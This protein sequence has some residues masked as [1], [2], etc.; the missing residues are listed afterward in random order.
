VIAAK[1]QLG[2]KVVPGATSARKM[3]EIT[4]MSLDE[5]RSRLA[6]DEERNR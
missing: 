4:G 3:I 1:C 6:C 2:I 5:V